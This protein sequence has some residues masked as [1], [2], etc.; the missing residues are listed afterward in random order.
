MGVPIITLVGKTVVGR[1]GLSQLTNLGLTE[2]IAKTPEQYL[3]IAAELARDL[4]RLAELRRTLRSRMQDS[5]LM[6]APR[7]ARN[8]EAAYRQMWQKWCANPKNQ[9]SG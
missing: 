1:A 4:P 7:F 9:I 5:P 6:D 2:L 8:I 3:S